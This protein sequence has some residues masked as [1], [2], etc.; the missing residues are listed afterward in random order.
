MTIVQKLYQPSLVVSRFLPRGLGEAAPAPGAFPESAKS[1]QRGGRPVI[2]WT[3]GRPNPQTA[4]PEREFWERRYGE[5][6]YAYG[7]APNDFLVEIADRIPPGPVLCLAEGEGRNAVWLAGRGHPLTAV[8]TSAAGLAKAE[9][10]ANARGVRIATVAADLASFVIEPKAWSGVVAIFAHL[11][12]HLR[13]SVHRAAARDWH[14]A[15][16]SS[17]RR[18]RRARSPWAPAARRDRSCSTPSRNCG[19]TW[20]ASTWRSAA[21]SNATSWRGCTTRGAPLSS[22]CLRDRRAVGRRAVA[23]GRQGGGRDSRTAGLCATSQY[24][25]KWRVQ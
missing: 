6:A 3:H 17:S 21:S 15:A 2:D 25:S 20:P 7:T 13:R 16:S 4:S 11:P 1:K 5:T 22:S 12:P 19:R 18:S 23:D 14:R 24:S 9:A 10:L 8:D